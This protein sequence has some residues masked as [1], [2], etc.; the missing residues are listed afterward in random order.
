MNA[1]AL[2]IRG[3]EVWSPDHRGTLDVLTIN[4]RIMA[5]GDHL[6]LPGWAPGEVLDA[7]HQLVMP[8][9]VDQHVHISG[10]GGEGGPQFRTPELQLTDLTRWG[11][12]TVVGLLGTDGTTRSVQELLAKARALAFDGLNTRIYTGAYEVPTRTITDSPRND[13]ILIGRIVGIGEI[14]IS[15]HRGSHPSDR[16]LA[17]LA[18]EARTGGLLAGKAGVLHLHVG[19]G[20]RRL[21]PL[22]AV[23]D[24]ADVPIGTMVPTHLNRTPELL[25]DAV[26]WGHRGGYLDITTSIAPDEHD[27]A[28]VSPVEAVKSLRQE[29]VVLDRISFSTDAG[30]SAP[31]FDSTGRLLHMG[32][33]SAQSL[34]NSVCSLHEQLSLEW[35]EALKPATVTPARILKLGDVGRIEV[36]ARADVVITD[37]REVRTVIAAGRVMVRDR[38]PVVWGMFEKTEG[39]NR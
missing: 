1:R 34:F 29:G 27:R 37:G 25:R 18:G 33:G 24:I 20:A 10:G 14:A 28:A 26:R 31:V 16:E 13:I 11:I 30:G 15:D 5:L 35:N 3:G 17:H 32:V 9:L 36:G 39:Q 4:D 19:S 21:D 22:L 8:G 2:L 23:L 12:T 6:E 38:E 7:R